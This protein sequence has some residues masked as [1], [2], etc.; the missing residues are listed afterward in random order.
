MATAG[1]LT[2]WVRELAG[3]VSFKALIDEAS[4]VPPGAN[5]LLTLPYFAGE[6]SPLF[7]ARA[8]GMIAGLT[9]THGR[10]EIARSVYEAIAFGIR[11]NLETISDAGARPDR[12]VAVGGGVRSNFWPQVVSDVTGVEQVIPAHAVGASYGDALMAGIGVAALDSDSDW[13]VPLETIA[14]SLESRGIYDRLY[15][16]YRELYLRTASISHQLAELQG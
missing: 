4:R 10:P 9:L 15:P 13:M 11:H 8:R 5:G 12:I 1:A 7:D 2:E 3:G 6:R 14:P 16:L